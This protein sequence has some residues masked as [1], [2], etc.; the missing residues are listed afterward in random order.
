MKV[1]RV[2]LTDPSV[3]PTDAELEALMQSMC[4]DVVKRH[5]AAQ[6]KFMAYVDRMIAEAGPGRGGSF[7]QA[8]LQGA[9]RHSSRIRD[10]IPAPN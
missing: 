5:G 10:V 7:R 9:E 2:D 3:E 6:K 4:E 1:P 8:G